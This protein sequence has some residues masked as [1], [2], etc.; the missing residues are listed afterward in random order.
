MGLRHPNPNRNP[1]QEWKKIWG[2]GTHGVDPLELVYTERKPPTFTV[3]T[4]GIELL[5]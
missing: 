5:A 4:E 1:N 3:T 2:Y